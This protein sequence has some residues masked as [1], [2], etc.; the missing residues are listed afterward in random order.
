MDCVH[1]VWVVFRQ[2]RASR[3]GQF[4]KRFEVHE[5]IGEKVAAPKRFS[6][7]IDVLVYPVQDGLET[8]ELQLPDLVTTGSTVVRNDLSHEESLP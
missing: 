5:V 4:S 2:R 8:L 7:V 3:E 1:P 6:V